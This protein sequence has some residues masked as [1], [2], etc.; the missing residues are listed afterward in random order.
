MNPPIAIFY[1]CLFFH[2][3]GPG[4]SPIAV[5][6][7]KEQMEQLGASGLLKAATDS[8]ACVNGGSESLTVASEVLSPAFKRFVFHGTESKS[9]NL[10][11]VQLEQWLPRHP[12]WHVLYFHA[13]GC[14]HDLA[15]TSDAGL[16]RYMEYS[17]KWRRCMMNFCVTGWRDCV[18][19]LSAGCD[20]AGCHWMPGQGSDHSQNIWG[21]NFWW[22]TSNFLLTLP[23]IFKRERIKLSGIASAESRYEAEVWIGNGPKLPRVK[24]FHPRGI[25]KCA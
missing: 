19:A 7:V 14:T 2:G 5:N 21:G 20:S 23:S 6:V 15:A 22:A 3:D 25:W 24:D 1:H 4:P 18:K 8:V 11:L 10:T 12:G 16:Q 17:P 13:K 9:E